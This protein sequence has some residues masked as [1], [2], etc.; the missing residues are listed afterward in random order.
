MAVHGV[1]QRSPLVEEAEEAMILYAY[2]GV[3]L[4]PP[5]RSLADAERRWREALA[6][7]DRR[8]AAFQQQRARKAK[9]FG[10]ALVR[11][12]GP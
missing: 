10:Q 3:P 8:A 9:A 12:R 2:G 5:A 11:S 1:H 7:G 4:D 6:A